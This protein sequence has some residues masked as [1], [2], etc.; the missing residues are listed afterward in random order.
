MEP[1]GGTPH[2]ACRAAVAKSRPSVA[3]ARCQALS[4]VTPSSDASASQPPACRAAVANSAGASVQSGAAARC[5]ASSALMPSA[6]AGMRARC[7]PWPPAGA[8]KCGQSPLAWPL[9]KPVPP[10][11]C[12]PVGACG[13]PGCG[14]ML[15][16]CGAGGACSVL[17]RPQC[18]RGSARIGPWSAPPSGAGSSF[19][20]SNRRPGAAPGGC[21]CAASRDCPGAA[22]GGWPCAAS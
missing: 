13:G 20:D 6:A 12:S 7:C 21:P 17:D 19:T 18:L 1:A 3:A 4:A 14:C 11:N 9:P 5:Q 16:P 10:G 22:T 15:H 2:P 8:P